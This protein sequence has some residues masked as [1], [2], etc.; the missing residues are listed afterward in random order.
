[1]SKKTILLA[2]LLCACMAVSNI[3]VVY[4]DTTS[5]TSSAASAGKSWKSASADNVKTQIQQFSNAL[6]KQLSVDYSSLFKISTLNKTQKA[7]FDKYTSDY[8]TALRVAKE[9]MNF[10]IDDINDVI[11]SNDDQETKAKMAEDIK[12]RARSDYRDTV[13][14]TQTYL[15]NCAYAMPT[16]TYQKFLKAFETNYVL[17]KLDME[18]YSTMTIR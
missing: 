2:G 15:S 9:S 17:G 16:L 10:Y 12:T 4:A 8:V 3:G 5:N 1:M 6:S 11:K 7:Q 13:T 14:A 18:R